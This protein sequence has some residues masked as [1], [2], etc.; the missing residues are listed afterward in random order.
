MA[1]FETGVVTSIPNLLDALAD[2]CVAN[3]WTEN[4]N[5]IEGTGRRVHLQLSSDV[6]I[7]LRALVNEAAQPS[8][9]PPVSGLAIN[10]STG[11]NGALAWYNQTG[12][13]TDGV[14]TYRMAGMMGISGAM[15]AYYFH[16]REDMIYVWLEY[17]TGLYQFMGFGRIEKYGAWSGGTVFFASA[18]GH[19]D[20]ITTLSTTL[21]G[22]PPTGLVDMV[23]NRHGYMYGTIGANTGW[24]PCSNFNTTSPDMPR[25][26]SSLCMQSLIVTNA[27]NQFNGLP[28]LLPIDIAVARD[29]AFAIAANT[30]FSIEGFLPDLYFCNLRTLIPGQQ[31][32]DGSGD[33]FR[34]YPFRQKTATGHSGGW[35]GVAIKEN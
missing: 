15:P 8:G 12:A 6:F 1:I 3:G 16:A 30:N 18:E 20:T 7:N 28:V 10:G 21:I 4:F 11:Y 5:A 26:F 25:F 29:G 14:T 27:A 32:D 34:I 35:F 31:L 23:G 33:I 2:F 22:E 17:A 13:P 24:L 19:S 9:F